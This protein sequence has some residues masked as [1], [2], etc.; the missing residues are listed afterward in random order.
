MKSH[1]I[2]QS[3]RLNH[4]ICIQT[5]VGIV[6]AKILNGNQ[7]IIVASIYRPTDNNQ[8]YTDELTS[9][10]T[11]LCVDNPGAAIWI[12]G[13]A[14]LPDINWENYTITSHQYKR[15]IN[16]AFL[17]LLD[18]TGL[19]QIVDF[20]TRGDRTLDIIMTNRPS[21]VNRC[22]SLPPLSDHDVVF[23]DISVR[24][25]RRKPVRR[26]IYLWKR[27]DFD[28]IRQRIK[29][30]SDHFTST[31]STSTPVEHLAEIMQLELDQIMKDNVP[32]KWSSTRYS[33][34]WFNSDTK[35]STRRKARAFKKARKTNR[36]RDWKRFRRLKKESQKSCRKAYNQYV[37]DIVCSDPSRGNNKKIGALVKSK[38]CDQM[39][40]SPLKEG[41]FLHT[42]PKTKA[43]ILN[44]QFTS[45]FSAD[46][47]SPL[48]DLGSSLHPT[49]NDITVNQNGVTK[50]LRNLKPSTASGPDGIPAMLL[51]ETAEEISPAV[52]LLFQSSINQGCV[53]SQW[54]NALIV[55]IYKKG[56]RS[57]AANYRPISLTPILCK[58][59][60]HLI[61]CAVIQHLSDQNILTDAQHGFRKRRSCDTQ[62]LAII[63][64]LAKGIDDKAQTD[65]ILLD[66][67]KAFDKVSHRHLLLK[68]E[69]YGIKGP[70]LSWISDFLHNRT[71]QVFLDGQCSSSSKVS[72]GVPQG[73]VLGPLLFLIFINDLPACVSNST[74]R[75]FADD[76]VVYRRI[77]SP[78][79]SIKLQQDLD[80]LQEW[81][82]KW[83]MKFNAT[84]CQVLQVTNKRNPITAS[85]SI[86]GHTLEVVS[87][88]KYLGVHL[89]THL[90][91]NAHIDAITRKANSIRGFLGRNLGHCTRKLKE[92]AYTI[93]VRPCVEYASCT[94]DPHTQRNIRKLEQ[95]QRSC[96]RFVTGDFG[97]QSSVSAML[98]DLNWT[99]LEERR[100][101]SR[102]A[103]MFKIHQNLVD[104][105][106]DQYLSPSSSTTRGH[107]SRFRIPQ[108][109]S[110]VYTMS[111]FPRTIRDW[112]NLQKD[113]AVYSSL[114]T[115]KAVL[116]DPLLM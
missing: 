55:P 12:A 2:P 87:S 112:N 97:Q 68:V 74:T 10:I 45:V 110:S 95:V 23:F 3:P 67:A 39:G 26:K 116:R 114:D 4:Q 99:T 88:A 48:P 109:K 31:Y 78:A 73:S 82:S 103:M 84:K 92:A 54:K 28:G 11:K 37:Y 15:S 113:P 32:S 107:S 61:H 22:C 5:E 56:S 57:D 19:D 36:L 71:Q 33:Q 47:N 6:A 44:R 70:T 106:E 7:S 27:T 38:R 81:E 91:F 13:D 96:A 93:F 65:V 43:N 17:H 111:F 64:D 75:I 35:R 66:Y 115:F 1:G 8:A 52:T 21:L 40:V 20:P 98:K 53:P 94:W 83:L 46:D 108:T 24:A 72:S 34:S 50:L 104:I 9:S 89:D 49:M 86:H 79:D 90:N 51:K 29:K 30:W 80:S 59:C 76:S 101:Q 69:H 25:I 60:E 18:T 14:N 58:L 63:D 102:L 105:R 77:S 16:E 42:D 85:Y 62:L 41:G 100:Y